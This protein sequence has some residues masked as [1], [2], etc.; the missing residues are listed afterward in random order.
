MEELKVLA[1]YS[2]LSVREYARMALKEQQEAA[3]SRCIDL[4]PP[5]LL[6]PLLPGDFEE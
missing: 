3:P 4:V 1:M 6:V 5:Q 2:I